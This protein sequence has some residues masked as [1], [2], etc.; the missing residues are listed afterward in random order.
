[1]PHD[2]GLRVS[3]TGPLGNALFTHPGGIGL[4]RG[5]DRLARHSGEQCPRA[6][7]VGYALQ[8]REEQHAGGDEQR[9]RDADGDIRRDS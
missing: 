1:M 6:Q 4:P 8:E 2:V 7:P 9:Q 5:A 3:P